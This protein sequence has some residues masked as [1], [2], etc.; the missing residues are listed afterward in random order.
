MGTPRR[1]TWVKLYVEGWLH[2]SIRWQMTSEERGVWADLLAFAGEIGQEGLFSDND[3]RPIPTDFIANRL[4]IKPELLEQVITG[5]LKEGRLIREKGTLKIANWTRY[6]SEYDRQKQY[7][8]KPP[9]IPTPVQSGDFSDRS[10]RVGETRLA[11]G[12]I[13]RRNPNG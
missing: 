4:N 10:L 12:E 6:Q 5:G 8:S 7:R 11:T 3:N 9:A 2:G 13:V 1:R